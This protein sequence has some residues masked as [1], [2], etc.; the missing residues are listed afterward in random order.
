[1]VLVDFWIYAAAV[2]MTF[3]HRSDRDRRLAGSEHCDQG[4]G[5]LSAY[6]PHEAEPARLVVCWDLA[7]AVSAQNG[8]QP[9]MN[10]W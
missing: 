1:M 2:S 7:L 4:A 9:T 5:R 8:P 6:Q 3:P 10:L